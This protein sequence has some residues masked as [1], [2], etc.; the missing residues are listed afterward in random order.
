MDAM[1]LVS[2]WE[3]PVHQLSCVFTRPTA[4]VWGQIALGWVLNRGPATVTN[5]LRTLGDSARPAPQDHA[6]V[7]V[8]IPSVLRGHALGPAK[9]S[10]A[11]SNYTQLEAL[12]PNGSKRKSRPGKIGIDSVAP[13]YNG[14]KWRVP[15]SI[16]LENLR[17]SR[18][19]FS[20]Y[21][22]QE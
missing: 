22:S 21:N 6:L 20:F 16:I 3:T 11:T 9:R 13:H 10:V 19:D 4:K 8:E 17:M 5:L 18:W 15:Y 2:A 7:R 14:G 12:W 1:T